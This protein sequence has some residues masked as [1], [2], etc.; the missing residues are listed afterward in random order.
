MEVPSNQRTGGGLSAAVTQTSAPVAPLRTPPVDTGPAPGKWTPQDILQFVKEGVTAIIG[1]LLVGATLWIA[2]DT[3]ALAG[4]GAKMEDGKTV[5]MLM[6][7]L[8]G[9]VTGYY[10]GRTPADARASQSESRGEAATAHA[11]QMAARS[12]EIAEQAEAIASDAAT[13]GVVDDSKRESL[14]V[15]RA[16]MNAMVSM[17]M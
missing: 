10:F 1:L 5:L 4:S 14:R 2:F 15:L 17:P 16:Q 6:M 3:F 11:L 13:R 12:T 8:A 9:V 7:G